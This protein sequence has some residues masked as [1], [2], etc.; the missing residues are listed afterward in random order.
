MIS[1]KF[2]TTCFEKVKKCSERQLLNILIKIVIA[3]AVFMFFCMVAAILTPPDVISQ[4]TLAFQMF[5]VFAVIWFIVSRFKSLAQT[6]MN[7]K[8]LIVVLVCLLSITITS[9]V[10]FFQCYYSSKKSYR[11][12]E[13][14]HSK[15]PVSP[16]QAQLENQ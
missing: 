13:I 9:S 7:I 2:I 11:Q 3:Y 16:N 12:L 14:E 10:F 8:I 1:N 4:I 15:S 6:P 5:F